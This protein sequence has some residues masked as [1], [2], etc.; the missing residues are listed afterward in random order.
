M[1]AGVER[2]KQ[3]IMQTQKAIVPTT[4]TAANAPLF[5][6]IWPTALIIFGFG[7]N[8]AWV[9]LLGYGLLSI[10]ALAF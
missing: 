9:V 2:E 8:A 4:Q 1:I 6:R 5:H 7:L 3:S 10:V